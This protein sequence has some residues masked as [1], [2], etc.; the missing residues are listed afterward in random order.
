MIKCIYVALLLVHMVRMLLGCL[1]DIIL[2]CASF[3]HF[4]IQLNSKL[5]TCFIF[6]VCNGV[7][8]SRFALFFPNK[9]KLIEIRVNKIYSKKE[10][11]S[12]RQIH[13]SIFVG[14]FDI[15]GIHHIS[16]S[17][18]KLFIYLIQFQAGGFSTICLL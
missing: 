13:C 9:V 2:S 10:K 14:T 6:A 12:K 15:R 16:L 3:F 4:N 7:K 1:Y 17:F 18:T 8:D 11:R 5:H